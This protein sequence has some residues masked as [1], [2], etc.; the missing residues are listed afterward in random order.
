MG[1]DQKHVIPKKPKSKVW[2]Y[3]GDNFDGQYAH[4]LICKEKNKTVSIKVMDGSTKGLR[5]HL[6]TLH[7]EEW[8]DVEQEKQEEQEKTKKVEPKSDNTPKI[9]DVFSKMSKV[10]PTGAKQTSYDQKLLELLACR[11]VPFELVDSPEFKAFVTELDK[12]INL[13]SARTYSRQLEKYSQEVL[14]DVKKAV[15]KFCT[16]SAAITTDL[17]TSRVRDSYIS[18]TLHF[19]DEMF[20]LHR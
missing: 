15:N 13:K 16:V 3:Y 8:K 7:T 2:K 5:V 1:G 10:N 9:A 14:E 4:C 12:S 6:K 20:R 19:V 18:I 11:Y 17:W